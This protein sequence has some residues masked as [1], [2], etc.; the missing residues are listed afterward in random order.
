MMSAWT[1]PWESLDSDLRE[2]LTKKQL[3]NPLIFA[4]CFDKGPSLLDDFRNLLGQ[5]GLDDN[6]ALT[7]ERLNSL[8]RLHEGAAGPAATTTKLLALTSDT[9]LADDLH[10]RKRHAGRKATADRR[11]AAQAEHLAG[12][13]G[14]WRG[15]RYR[16]KEEALNPLEREQA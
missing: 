13:P 10:E 12:L 16:R 3:S 15:K 8:L 5:L 4:A 7:R 6:P 2:E 1:T 11:S 14:Q 9:Q